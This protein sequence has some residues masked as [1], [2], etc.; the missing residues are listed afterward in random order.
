MNFLKKR[1]TPVQNIAFI[2]IMAAINVVFVLISSLLPVLLFLL[3][4]ILPLTSVFVTIYCKKSFFPVYFVSTIALCLAVTA[5]FSIFDTF[6]YV[7]PSLVVGFIFGISIEKQVPAV[8]ILIINSI[9]LYGF[10]YLTFLFIERVI[11]QVNLFNSIYTLVGLENFA[12]KGALTHILTYLIAQIQIILTYIVV[13]YQATRLGL[14]IR[15]QVKNR[16]WMYIIMFLGGILT[17]LSYFFFQ[18]VAILLTLMVLPITVYELIDLAL[19]KAVWIYVTLGLLTLAFMF[20]FAFL[21]SYPV[22]PN[23]LVLLYIFFGGVTIIDFIS[24][25]CLKNK[26][27]TIQ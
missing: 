25:Y 24:N 14:E 18:D 8:Y 3:V 10:T 26:V 19:K 17:I 23:Q 2:A 7:L 4:F 20:I 15:L 27:Q 16:L 21:Y 13:R 12:Y 1:E 22:K 9:I 6:I 11:S 5:G